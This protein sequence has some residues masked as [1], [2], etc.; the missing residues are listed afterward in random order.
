M[1]AKIH[2]F[3]FQFK[4]PSELPVS[5]EGAY[6]YVRYKLTGTIESRLQPNGVFVVPITILKT[7]SAN[8]AELQV[9]V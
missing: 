4:L 9:C 1:T 3:P 7:I 2:R 8:D 6:G 5:F